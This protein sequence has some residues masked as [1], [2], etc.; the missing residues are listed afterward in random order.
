M[1]LT[2]MGCGA[3]VISGRGLVATALAFGLAI[4]AMA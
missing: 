1:I 4:V 2:L 3:T